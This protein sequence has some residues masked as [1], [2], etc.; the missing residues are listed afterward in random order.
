M[1]W[2]AGRRLMVASVRAHGMTRLQVA[3]PVAVGPLVEEQVPV[4]VVPLVEEQVPVAVV[5]FEAENE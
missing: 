3:L 2:A 1:F 4:A 5:P